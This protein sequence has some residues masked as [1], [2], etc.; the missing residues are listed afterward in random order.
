M[1]HVLRK[2]N[3]LLLFKCLVIESINLV[4]FNEGVSSPLILDVSSHPC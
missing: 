4:Y 2:K 3:N 1:T